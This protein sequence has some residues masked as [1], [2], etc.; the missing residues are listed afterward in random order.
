[1]T[2]QVALFGFQAAVV[3]ATTMRIGAAVTAVASCPWE[4]T[5]TATT[6]VPR[7]DA[8]TLEGDL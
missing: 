3:S 8:R 5:S 7:M 2:V 6:K 4:A 1:M